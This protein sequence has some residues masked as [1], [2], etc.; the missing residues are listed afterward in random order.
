MESKRV[1]SETAWWAVFAMRQ[2][3]HGVRLRWV[4]SRRTGQNERRKRRQ[5]RRKKCLERERARKRGQEGEKR[6]EGR[7]AWRWEEKRKVYRTRRRP[8]RR[9]H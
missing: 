5:M 1:L 7:G 2:R 6:W 4:A 3:R 9:R 8:N